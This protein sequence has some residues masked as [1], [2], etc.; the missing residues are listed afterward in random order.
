MRSRGKTVRIIQHSDRILRG[1]DKQL[2]GAI[3]VF[4]CLIMKL[5]NFTSLYCWIVYDF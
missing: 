5:L 3:M 1:F 2:S 4:L